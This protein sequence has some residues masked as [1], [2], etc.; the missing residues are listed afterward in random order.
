MHEFYLLKLKKLEKSIG[1]MG[2]NLLSGTR[3]NP[4]VMPMESLVIFIFF[5][6]RNLLEYADLDS[7]KYSEMPL[8]SCAVQVGH[9]YVYMYTHTHTRIVCIYINL[10]ILLAF[11][12]HHLKSNFKSK[13]TYNC[14]F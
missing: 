5:L 2:A 11:R 3:A 8:N 9:T 12:G 6:E 1:R 14:I 10:D 7:D 13:I 4:E